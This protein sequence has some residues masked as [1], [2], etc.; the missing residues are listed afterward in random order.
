M[1]NLT[2][3]QKRIDKVFVLGQDYRTRHASEGSNG[4]YISSPCI[5]K[6]FIKWI[7]EEYKCKLRHVVSD[8]DENQE[9]VKGFFEWEDQ[10]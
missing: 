6:T 3:M 1:I 9:Y 7:E 10:K 4:F 5:T 8:E 2:D